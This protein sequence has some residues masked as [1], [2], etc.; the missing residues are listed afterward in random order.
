MTTDIEPV[1]VPDS[2]LLHTESD[3][4]EQSQVVGDWDDPGAPEEPDIASPSSSHEAAKYRR[5]LRDTEAE[6]DLLVTRVEV[7]QRAEI[8][9]LAGSDLAVPED[10][11]TIGEVS[12]IDLLDE[13]GMVDRDKVAA[14][15]E[16]LIASRPGLHADASRPY[17][18]THVN[19]GQ[20]ATGHAGGAARGT[21][22]QSALSGR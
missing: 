1:R 7:L 16:G 20:G 17:R 5:R 22:W 2:P 14:A 4:I 9:R 8:L 15:V 21:S 10:I 3:D 6:R 13:A 18:A 19:W 12:P 11:F